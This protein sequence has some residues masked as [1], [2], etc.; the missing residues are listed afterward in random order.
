MSNQAYKYVIVGG[1]LAGASAVAGIREYDR[2]GS[3][4]LIGKERHLPYDRPPLS[5]KLWFGQTKVEEISVHD[6]QFYEQNGVTLTLATEVVSLDPAGKTVSDATGNRYGYQKLLLATGGTPRHLPVPGSD[7]D[8]ICYYRYLD[9]YLRI[10][11]EAAE[12][13]S[14]VV[15]GGG[16]I[17]S[18]IAAALNLNKLNVTMVMPSSYL[19]RRVFP[20]YLGQ[21]LLRRYRQRGVTMLTGDRPISFTSSGRGLVTHTQKGQHVSSDLVIVGVG[22]APAA[23]LAQQAG[24]Q[25]SDGIEV[26]A[27][28]RTSHPDVYAAG[29]NALFPYH[30]LG[31]RMRIEHWDNAVN[32]GRWAGRNMA[33]AGEPFTYMPYFFSDLFEFGYE[34]VGEVSSELNTFAD[35]QKENDTGVVYYL[36]EG[37]IRGVMMCNVWEKVEAA[38]AL[39]RKGEQVK[40]ESLLGAIR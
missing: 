12:G 16:F 5:K 27:Y 6:R 15:V 9:D 26:D 35:W 40:P 20:E 3:V 19:C 23:E 22:I 24:L 13:K 1:G 17:G 2:N 39:I 30:A 7:L 31:S 36:R 21:E 32:Q 29:D 37:K 33:G 10:R 25:T 28:L 14:A 34:A 4:L 38:R 8:G 11:G 18:E